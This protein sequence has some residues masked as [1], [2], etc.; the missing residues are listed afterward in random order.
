MSVVLI[1]QEKC[2]DKDDDW[3]LRV[4]GGEDNRDVVSIGAKSWKPKVTRV[5]R[6]KKME[7]RNAKVREETD[8]EPC[9]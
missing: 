4:G 6:E 3:R 5:G 8:R 2:R 7:E 9:L 1:L